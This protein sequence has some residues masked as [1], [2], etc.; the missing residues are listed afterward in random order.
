ML[1]QS[2]IHMTEIPDTWKIAK[3]VVIPKPGKDPA[4]P[5][6]YRLISLLNIDYKMLTSILAPRLNKVLGFYIHTDQSGFLKNRYFIPDNTR[7]IQNIINYVN[8][9]KKPSLLYFVY[10][11][12]AFDLVEWEYMKQIMIRISLGSFFL[13]WIRMIYSMQVAEVVLDRYYSKPIT[14]T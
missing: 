9:K 5:Q 8:Y 12:K 11:E 6:S 14:L 1:F 13:T 4:S 2:C 10:M 7:R 3:I